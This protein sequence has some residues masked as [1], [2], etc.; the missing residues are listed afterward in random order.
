MYF[1]KTDKAGSVRNRL[2]EHA[3]KLRGRRRIRVDDVA[4]RYLVIEEDWLVR[5][6]EEYLISHYKPSWQGSGFGSHVPGSGRPGKRGPSRFDREF[7]P[8][9][10]KRAKARKKATSPQRPS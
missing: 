7:P 10:L 4:F 8:I 3:E 2:T 9:K 1:G 6:C 5:A